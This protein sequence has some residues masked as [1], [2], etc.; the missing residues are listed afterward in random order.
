MQVVEQGAPCEPEGDPY[1]E[2]QGAV[3]QALRG[4]DAAGEAQQEP[5]FAAARD[6]K[7]DERKHYGADDVESAG[8]GNAQPDYIKHEDDKAER[9]LLQHKADAQQGEGAAKEQRIGESSLGAS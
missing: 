6:G 2:K 9:D 3:E 7:E 1:Q 8:I 5:C 4:H